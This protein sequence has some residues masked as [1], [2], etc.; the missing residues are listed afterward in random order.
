MSLKNRVKTLARRS[1][2]AV[3]RIL[4]TTTTTARESSPP[5]PSPFPSPP[6]SPASPQVQEP[7]PAALAPTLPAQNGVPVEIWFGL[8]PAHLNEEVHPRFWHYWNNWELVRERA[9][10]RVPELPRARSPAPRAGERYEP[11][12]DDS[13]IGTILE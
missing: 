1:R 6:L 4:T 12:P 7:I 2:A 13:T 11:G 8:V 5:R 3:R 9:A 10:E